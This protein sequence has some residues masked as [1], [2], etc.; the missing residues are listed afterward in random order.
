MKSWSSLCSFCLLPQNQPVWH[1]CWQKRCGQLCPLACAQ[2]DTAPTQSLCSSLLRGDLNP[3]DHWSLLLLTMLW[4]FW[5]PW[6]ENTEVHLLGQGQDSP[7][8]Q[9]WLN[10]QVRSSAEPEAANNTGIPNP[11]GF[12]PPSSTPIALPARAQ[13]N[14]A[15]HNR[16]T[17]GQN[18]TVDF[19]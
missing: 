4:P 8:L 6:S 18:I 12:F 2:E 9:T 15:P 13:L 1:Q 16:N 17:D 11:V 3:Y 14:T 10:T 5:H 19:T 7:S